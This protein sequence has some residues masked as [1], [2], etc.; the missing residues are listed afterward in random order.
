MTV[1]PLRMITMLGMCLVVDNVEFSAL[2]I[3]SVLPRHVALT[4]F[5]FE[6]EDTIVRYQAQIGQSQGSC[7]MG[8]SSCVC[9]W[10]PLVRRVEGCHQVS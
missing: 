7:W 8:S 3:K 4:I 10:D 5:L 6:T 9:S 1:T 2:V